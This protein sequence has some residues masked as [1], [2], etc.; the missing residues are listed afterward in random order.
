MAQD[1]FIDAA[2]NDWFLVDGTTIR[3]CESK[4]ELIRQQLAINLRMI[5]GEWFA[6]TNYGIPYFTSVY[7][8]NTQDEVDLIFKSAI[9]NTD[10]VLA[11]TRFSSSIDK[12]TRKYTLVFSVQ[13]EVGPITDIEVVT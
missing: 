3:L 1:F 13:T 7:G 9:R 4:Q 6:N 2:T 8:K 12:Q 11:I 10:G 5:R